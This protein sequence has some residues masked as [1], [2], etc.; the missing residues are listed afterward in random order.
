VLPI[1]VS[2]E[3]LQHGMLHATFSQGTT[4]HTDMSYVDL[5]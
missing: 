2:R 4:P 3:P 1:N 5:L